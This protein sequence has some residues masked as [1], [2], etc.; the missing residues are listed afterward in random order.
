MSENRFG[1]IAGEYDNWSLIDPQYEPLHKATIEIVQKYAAGITG[2]VVPVCE[3]GYGTGYTTQKLI[4]CDS[5]I[6]VT[7]IDISSEMRQQALDRLEREDLLGQAILYIGDAQILGPKIKWYD[8]VASV[9]TMHNID[10]TA[11]F[12]VCQ[13]AWNRLEPGGLWVSGDKVAHDDPATYLEL[14]TTQIKAMELYR[15]RGMHFAYDFWLRHEIEDH[16]RRITE[17]ETIA[18]LQE[19]GFEQVEVLRRFGLYA[20]IVGYKPE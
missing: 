6:H 9:C 14:F 17:A 12:T 8:I 19:A 10:P 2:N 1:P 3:I 16:I 13:D 15:E 18:M 7:G 11:R 5:R 4:E 20:L